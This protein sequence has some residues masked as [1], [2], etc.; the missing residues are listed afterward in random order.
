MKD[1][2]IKVALARAA[3]VAAQPPCGG[4]VMTLH[5]LACTSRKI[6]E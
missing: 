3:H 2:A 5:R 1:D 4:A 6:G